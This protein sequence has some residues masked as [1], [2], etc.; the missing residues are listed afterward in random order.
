MTHTLNTHPAGFA[1]M[2]G[3]TI[4]ARVSD[5]QQAGKLHNRLTTHEQ[6][7]AAL[8]AVQ[9]ALAGISVNCDGVAFGAPS[10]QNLLNLQ[11]TVNDAIL[12]AY[13]D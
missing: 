4:L 7:L 5:A 10:A 2:E 9:K 6:L 13:E 1:I 11:R 3:D 12:S 8:E